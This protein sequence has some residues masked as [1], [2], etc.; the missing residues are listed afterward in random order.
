MTQVLPR[1]RASSV[2]SKDNLSETSAE[3][4]DQLERQEIS[5]EL[6]QN[7]IH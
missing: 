1:I 5:G 6:T 4:G 2:H 3:S 7:K